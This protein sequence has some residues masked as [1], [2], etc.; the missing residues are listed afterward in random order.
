MKDTLG[1]WMLSGVVTLQTGHLLTIT[2]VNGNNVLGIASH[3]AEL[4]RLID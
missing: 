1:G 3:F 2:G 4:R